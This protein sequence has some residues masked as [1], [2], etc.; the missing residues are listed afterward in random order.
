MA[1]PAQLLYLEPDD[2][3]T[4]V[5]RRLREADAGRVV[6]VA[7]GRS[8]VTTSA[9]ALRLLAGVAEEDGRQIALVSD[10]AGRALAAEAGIDAYPSV[11]DANAEDP[12]PPEPPPARRASIRVVR[13]EEARV[14]TLAPVAAPGSLDETMVVPVERATKPPPRPARAPR[15][16]GSRRRIVSRA[17][18]A[19][20]VVLLVLAAAGAAA[21]AP[22]AT[23]VIQP[24]SIPIEPVRYTLSLPA[25]GVDDRELTAEAQGEASG[26]FRDPSPASGVVVFSNWNTVDVLVSAGTRVAAGDV[27][28]ETVEDVTVPIGFFSPF[29]PGEAAA[30][31]VA[32]DPGPNGNVPSEAID[33]IVTDGVRAFLRGHP[34]N[35]NRLVRNPDATAGGSDNRQP[36]IT[37]RDVNAAANAIRTDLEAQLAAALVEEPGL[38]YAEME[39]EEPVIDVPDDLVGRRGEASFT[40][41]GR[42]PYSRAWVSADEAELAARDRLLDDVDA[43]PPGRSLV[44]DSIGIEVRRVTHEGEVVE[45]RVTVTA[46]AEPIVDVGEVRAMVAGLPEP[47]AAAALAGLGQ[48]QI[49]LWPGWVDAVPQLEWRIDVQVEPTVE[50]SASP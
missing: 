48:V 22:S 37:R 1:D 14:A 10:S 27:V 5:V 17:A 35:P 40:L 43:L 7:P 16:A 8:R 50:A 20:L 11:A 23:I 3:I 46:L 18:V 15:P 6:L 32:L 36:E 38:L 49:D 12:V 47:D 44:E 21:V 25:A 33:R 2:E 13:G 42:L 39:V 45:V 9:V 34:D 4:S 29:A 19:A 26:V 41:A 24:A 31:V 30:G 28:F